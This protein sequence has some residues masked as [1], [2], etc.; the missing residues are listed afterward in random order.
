[1]NDEYEGE[2]TVQSYGNPQ[3]SE[4]E[5]RDD[6]EEERGCDKAPAMGSEATVE[7]A[8]CSGQLHAPNASDF[9]LPLKPIGKGKRLVKKQEF[10]TPAFSPEQRLLVLDVWNR[11][12]LSAKDFAPLVGVSHHSLYTWKKLFDEHGPAGLIGQRRGGPKGSR[13]PEVTKRTIL[14]IKEG[15]PDYGCQRISDMLARGPG[16]GASPGSVLTVLKE[17][18][19][20]TQEEATRPHAA[21]VHRFERARPGL[22]WQTD[23]FSFTLKRQNRRVYLVAFLDDHARFITAFGLHAS[24]TTAFVIEALRSGMASYGKPEEVLSD[25]GPQYVTWRGKS[26][27][28]KELD[29]Q[30]IKH[31]V[32][33]PRHPQTLGKIERFWQSLW[34]ECLEQATFMDVEEA[35][36]RLAWY[37][38]HYNLASYYV[39]SLCV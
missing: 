35:R 33:R 5:S 29:K 4:D 31:L 12:G 34:R 25:N 21:V 20:E 23:L 26:A 7:A 19:Y 27:F 10:R 8:A 11:S 36:R 3:A 37:I 6:A 18:G 14:M 15:N 24:A 30:G 28:R 39:T 1:M 17:A 16:L 13:L 9:F 22:M 38:D 2:P 32:S